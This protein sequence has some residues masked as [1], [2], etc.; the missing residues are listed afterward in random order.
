MID[1]LKYRIPIRVRLTLWYVLLLAITFTVFAVYLIFRFQHSLKST[2]DASLQIAVSSTIASLDMEDYHDTNRLAFNPGGQSQ[3][4]N[5]NFVMRLISAQSEVWDIS[6]NTQNISFWGPAKAGYTTQTRA[7]NEDEWRVFSQP[8]LDSNGQTIGWVQAA[9]SLRPVND[10]VDDLREQLLL[11]FPLILLFAGI[12]GYFLANRA[13][14]PIQ[15]ITETAQEI[16]ARDL[17]KRIG[18]QGSTDEVGRLAQTFDEMLGRLQS[19]FERE[20]RFTSD[21]AHEL[22]TPLTVLKGQIEVTLNR[23]R[24]PAEYEKSLRE[25]S[26]QVDR[27]IRLSNALLFLSRSD[28]RQIT[29]QPAV[30]NLGELLEVLIEQIGPLAHQKELKITMKMAGELYVYGDRDHLISLFMNLLENALK[31]TPAGGQVTLTAVKESDE[32]QVAIHNTGPGIPQEHLEHLFERFY[33]VDADRSSQT[34]GSGLGLAIAHEIARLHGGRISAQ[35]ES[36]QGVKFTVHLPT[37]TN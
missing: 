15:Q 13:L 1:F 14:R 21:A 24:N 33:R 4:P 10:A 20:R 35:S 11:G 8:I 18:Y 25:L 7:E 19:S 37:S 26:A 9:Q 23:P 3:A 29:F 5:P 12:G 6:S 16:R 34:G 28:Q 31:Y 27:L 17:S 2:I 32:S 30:I 36:G 22:R